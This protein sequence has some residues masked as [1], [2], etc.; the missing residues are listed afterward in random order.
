MKKSEKVGHFRREGY[1]LQ[2]IFIIVSILLVRPAFAQEGMV[3]KL[4]ESELS[5]ILPILKAEVTGN[6][7]LINAAASEQD[8]SYNLF[9]DIKSG[10][11]DPLEWLK[12]YSKHIIVPQGARY[13]PECSREVSIKSKELFKDSESAMK[14]SVVPTAVFTFGKDF[15]AINKQLLGENTTNETYNKLVE[16]PYDAT[17]PSVD[18]LRLFIKDMNSLYTK[19][20]FSVD[21]SPWEF[22]PVATAFSFYHRE[23]EEHIS[24]FINIFDFTLLDPAYPDVVKQCKPYVM[25]PVLEIQAGYK[26]LDEILRSPD[27][28]KPID[29][30]ISNSLKKAGISEERY[31]LIKVSLIRARIDSDNPDAIEVPDFEFVAATDEEKETARIIE[32][33]KADALA[34][35][36][37]VT[38]YNK[39]KAELDPTLD[40]LQQYIH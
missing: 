40:I 21:Y 19:N 12:K 34:R 20:G 37:N 13:L 4:S 17:D 35:K 10:K 36:S 23:D 22:L 26:L 8:R 7:Q 31:A 14:P 38:I 16:N 1:L 15:P 6:E 24:G 28:S 33:M 29:E 39:H 11:T 5:A 9:L 18:K 32:Q 27:N 3:A 25:G 30:I 2:I